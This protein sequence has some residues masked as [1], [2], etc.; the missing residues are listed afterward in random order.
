MRVEFAVI[1]DILQDYLVREILFLSWKSQGGILITYGSG[2]HTKVKL[3]KDNILSPILQEFS[4]FSNLGLCL[5]CTQIISGFLG[6]KYLGGR[7]GVD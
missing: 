7:L 4:K 3:E 1:S 6:R 5:S 2:N